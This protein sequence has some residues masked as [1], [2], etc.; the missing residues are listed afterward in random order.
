[1]STRAPTMTLQI[2]VRRQRQTIRRRGLGNFRT[3]SL[4]P[5]PP[6]RQHLKRHQGQTPRRRSWLSGRRAASPT[7]I[8][9]GF[10]P[11]A[12][13]HP[14]TTGGRFTASKEDTALRRSRGVGAITTNIIQTP[15]NE[16]S[17]PS[18]RPRYIYIKFKSSPLPISKRQE[19][20]VQAWRCSLS[21]SFALD[22]IV[23]NKVPLYYIIL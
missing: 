2:W 5:R 21:R 10:Q 3:R 7:F 13:I 15:T 12:A 8:G 11:A 1:M 4:A 22:S 6:C 23:D 20:R 18:R 17:P 19:I 14:Y 16:I 9:T